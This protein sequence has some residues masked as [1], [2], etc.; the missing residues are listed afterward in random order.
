M[1]LDFIIAAAPAYSIV[2]IAPAIIALLFIIIFKE[3]ANF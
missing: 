1:D 2:I 3:V